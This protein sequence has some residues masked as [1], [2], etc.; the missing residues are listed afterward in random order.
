MISGLPDIDRN[1]LINSFII[2]WIILSKVADLKENTEYHNYNTTDN[3]IV[4]FW[5]ILSTYDRT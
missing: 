1:Y 3:I 2:H 4:W 5:E